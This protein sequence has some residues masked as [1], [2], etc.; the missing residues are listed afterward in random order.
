M[1]EQLTKAAELLAADLRW[2][3][4]LAVNAYWASYEGLLKSQ[5]R[6]DCRNVSSDF[7]ADRERKLFL[8]PSRGGRH[9]GG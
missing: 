8:S 2:R 9:A 6:L 7:S 1:I 3:D 4:M 5:R